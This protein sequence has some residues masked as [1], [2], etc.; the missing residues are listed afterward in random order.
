[1]YH[2]AVVFA[3]Q[4]WVRKFIYKIS[5]PKCAWFKEEVYLLCVLSSCKTRLGLHEQ[6]S[7]RQDYIGNKMLNTDVINSLQDLFRCE[8]FPIDGGLSTCTIE[9]SIEWIFY[10]FFLLPNMKS[11]LASLC[12]S[13]DSFE[14]YD[15]SRAKRMR[16]IHAGQRR[17]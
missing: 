9:P 14:P 3:W 1:M 17:C 10:F 5:F 11:I 7:R 4:P 15:G 8:L 12:R 6:I 13:I 2:H 16:P